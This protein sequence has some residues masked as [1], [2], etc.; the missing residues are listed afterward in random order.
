MVN[1]L[2]PC[3]MISVLS[4]LV[5]LLPVDAGEKISLAITV[6]LAYTIMLIMIAD[7][8]PKSSQKMPYISEFIICLFYSRN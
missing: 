4:C 6:S 2:A 3:F 8:T 7:V 1:V 5:F